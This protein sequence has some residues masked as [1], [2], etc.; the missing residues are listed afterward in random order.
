MEPK[1]DRVRVRVQVASEGKMCILSLDVTRALAVAVPKAVKVC[2][3]PGAGLAQAVRASLPPG[4]KEPQ[5][6]QAIQAA[7]AEAGKAKVSA[8]NQLI[9]SWAQLSISVTSH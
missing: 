3:V 2:L 5:V 9:W 8:R 1:K 4:T 6:Q 7:T